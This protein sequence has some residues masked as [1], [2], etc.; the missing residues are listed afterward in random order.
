MNSGPFYGEGNYS[1]VITQQAMTKAST[2][3]PQFVIR[4]RVLQ[5][6]DGSQVKQQ[7]ERTI[8]R[9][10]TEKTVEYVQKDLEALGFTGG[11]LRDLDPT[12][13]NFFDLSGK[14]IEVY[15]KHEQN[16]G[17]MREKWN[18]S[19]GISKPI[20]GVALDQQSYRQLDALF[21]L[22]GSRQSAPAARRQVNP[23]EE[24]PSTG[25]EITDED[26]PF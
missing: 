3:T 9:A 24:S 25:P 23:F 13:P 21:G 14:E 22:N 10:L 2:G 16:N 5:C 18:I 6:S 26:I 15:C 11:S 8:Y 7:Y 20:E 12:G 1:G 4:F 19:R 17:E